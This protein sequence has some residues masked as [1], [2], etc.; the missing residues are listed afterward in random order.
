M[1]AVAKTMGQAIELHLKSYARFKP[2]ATAANVAVVNSLMTIAVATYKCC[3]YGAPSQASEI[4]L[5]A[6][7][8]TPSA[9]A[10]CLRFGDR[11]LDTFPV[12]VLLTGR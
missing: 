5:P 10:S 4:E 2:D 8:I 6:N 11:M 9:V 12:W 3:R 7:R 1:F